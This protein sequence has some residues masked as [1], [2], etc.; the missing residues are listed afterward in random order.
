ML[1]MLELDGFQLLFDNIYEFVTLRPWTCQ[2]IDTKQ[3]VLV[4]LW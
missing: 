2:K 4:F 3:A 1:I